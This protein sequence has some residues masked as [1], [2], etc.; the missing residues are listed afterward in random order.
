MTN[1]ANKQLKST[2]K[3]KFKIKMFTTWSTQINIRT[4]RISKQ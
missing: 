2:S 3:L 1:M 4:N